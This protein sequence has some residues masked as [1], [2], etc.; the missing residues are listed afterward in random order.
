MKTEDLLS[1]PKALEDGIEIEKYIIATYTAALKPK[2]MATTLA[3]FAAIEQSTGTWIR[4]PAE[5]DAVRKNHVAKVLGVYEV[6]N[7]E[8]EVPKEVTERL[9]VF[10]IAFPVLNMMT[11]KNK[12]NFPLMFT[13]IYGNISMGGK[14]KLVDIQ[15]PK[16]VLK[17]FKGPKFGTAGFQKLLGVKG[18]PILNN[19]IKP[20]TGHSCEVAGELA[21][22]A[23]RGGCDVIKDDELIADA[24]FNTLEDRLSMVMEA[25]DRAD[26]DK[27]EKT[28]YTIGICDGYPEILEHANKVQDMGGNGLLINYLPSGLSML[29]QIAED[30]SIKI[31]ILAHMDFAGVWYQDQWSGVASNLTLGKIPRI[32]GADSIVL[33]APYGKAVVVPERFFMNIKELT[34]P[35]HKIKP[36]MPMPS[37]GITAGMV[38]KCVRDCGIDVMIGSGGGVHA[39][40]DGPYAGAQSLR[41][42]ID[43]AVKGIPAKTY[44]KDHEELAKAIGV[45]GQGKTK[46]QS[47]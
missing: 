2:I 23:A 40:P 28:I 41:Q 22:E 9:Y 10:R 5:T 25:L 1:T 45:W 14:L 39:H 26:S 47:I 12:F 37:G 43:A 32:C 27:G 44:A 11:S 33:P 4:V 38:Q 19:M 6:P 36:T 21:Y 24:K 46:F 15:F 7:F 16:A 29:R 20:C 35:L 42:A 13:A 8:Y 34:Y 31:P 18:R 17:H 3:Q 30:P